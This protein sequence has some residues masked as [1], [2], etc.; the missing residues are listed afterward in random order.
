LI[1]EMKMTNAI[2]HAI[3]LRI[4]AQGRSCST[5]NIKAKG[6]VTSMIRMNFQNRAPILAPKIKPI[7]D[8]LL[9]ADILEK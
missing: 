3:E 1:S 7:I 6:D 2:T 8:E 4:R 9:I 5:T